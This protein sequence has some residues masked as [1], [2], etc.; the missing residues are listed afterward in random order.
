MANCGQKRKQNI[1]TN[2]F[3]NQMSEDKTKNQT[4]QQTVKRGHMTWKKMSVCSVF[5]RSKVRKNDTTFPILQTKKSG[6]G[7]RQVEGFYSR[8]LKSTRDT[9]LGI[10]VEMDENANLQLPKIFTYRTHCTCRQNF[11]KNKCLK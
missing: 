10:S 1:S 11:L 9:T 7:L 8:G 5:K 6:K 4:S 2:K 3:L